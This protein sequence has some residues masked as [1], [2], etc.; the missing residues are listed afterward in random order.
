MIA[1]TARRHIEDGASYT[2]IAF[3]NNDEAASDAGHVLI[4]FLLSLVG[5]DRECPHG[6]LP[7]KDG[8]HNYI[9]IPTAERDERLAELERA[10]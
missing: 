7:G 1:I 6:Y 2:R 9:D 3:A 10:P 4:E 5:D 8:G